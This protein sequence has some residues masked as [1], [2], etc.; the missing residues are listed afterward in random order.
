[1]CAHI[2]THWGK[3]IIYL[4]HLTVIAKFREYFS[5]EKKVN[6]MY[7]NESLA[8]LDVFYIFKHDSSVNG[9]NIFL[10]RAG[11]ALLQL[12]LFSK[13]SLRIG[14]ENTKLARFPP[15]LSLR[16]YLEHAV[17]QSVYFTVTE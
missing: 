5:K 3:I 9:E 6:S 12:V 16:S 13:G 15:P 7:I 1:M 14:T 17:T 8:L 2:H 11:S 4:F 10:T